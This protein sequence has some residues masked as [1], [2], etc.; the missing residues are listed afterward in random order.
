MSDH[1]ELSAM[2]QYLPSVIGE[3]IHTARM[4]CHYTQEQLAEKAGITPTH[5][6]HIESGHRNPSLEVL[7]RLARILHMS[8]DDLIFPDMASGRSYRTYY[9]AECM[10]RCCNEKQLRILIAAMGVMLE[11]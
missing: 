4:D 1:D 6:K 10:L 2:R 5:L 8:L 9:K 7:Y 3:A 11:E